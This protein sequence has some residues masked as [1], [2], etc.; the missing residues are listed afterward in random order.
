MKRTV[1][2]TIA[3]VALAGLVGAGVATADGSVADSRLGRVLSGLVNQGTIT[4][5][6][7]D[8]VEQALTDAREEARAEHEAHRAEQREEVDA[9][10]EETLGMTMEELRERLRAGDT[11]LDIAGENA[12]DLAAGMAQLLSQQLDE[13][14]ADGRMSQEQADALRARAA[15]RSEA[16]LAGEQLRG[17]GLGLLVGPGG[18]HGG[19]GGHGGHAPRGMDHDEAT[20]SSD[21][22]ADLTKATQAAWEV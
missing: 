10:L 18:G 5:E 3:G 2:A 11:L 13:A 15:E 9:L 16:W 19:R 22:A 20:D 8:E 7:A 4:Q 6:E 21:G 1:T 14:V 17:G 12:D